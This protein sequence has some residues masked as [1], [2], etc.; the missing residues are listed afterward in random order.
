ME[1]LRIAVCGPT[2]VGKTTF[3]NSILGEPIL[4]TNRRQNTSKITK[5]SYSEKYKINDVVYKKEEFKKILNKI[6]SPN[7]ENI[8]KPRR[9]LKDIIICPTLGKEYI[10]IE[11]PQTDKRLILFDTPGFL[12]YKNDVINELINLHIHVLIV[13]V[14]PNFVVDSNIFNENYK[15]CLFL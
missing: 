12:M 9:N 7:V 11:L 15:K 13:L 5:I 4:P 14:D 2:S 8:Q 1:E 3:I 6:N 10:K